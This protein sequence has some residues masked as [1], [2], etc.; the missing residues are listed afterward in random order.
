MQEAVLEDWRDAVRSRLGQV[1]DRV[2]AREVGVS[3]ELVRQYRLALNV[4]RVLS[5]G[6]T[7]LRLKVLAAFPEDGRVL[8]LAQIAQNAY[9]S[10]EAWARGSVRP[11]VYWLV[12]AG[13][14]NHIRRGEYQLNVG[15]VV[16]PPA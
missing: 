1:P 2:L 8:T 13:H 6:M 11:V 9:G 7:L 14:V 10:D 15:P 16:E 12:D 4:P 3:H 5:D